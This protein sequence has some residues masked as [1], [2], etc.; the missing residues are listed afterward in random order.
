L[1]LRGL[2]HLEAFLRRVPDLAAY[3]TPGQSNFLAEFRNSTNG[4]GIPGHPSRA[5]LDELEVS[6]A[7][8]R[9]AWLRIARV[10]ARD[11][12]GDEHVYVMYATSHLPDRERYPLM[13]DLLNEWQDLPGTARRV[14][15][16]ASHGYTI[17]VL[18]TPE[19]QKFLAA[20][21]RSD[22]AEIRAAGA[23]IARELKD[24]HDRERD[25]AAAWQAEEARRKAEDAAARSGG[26]ADV[27]F[28]PLTFTVTDGSRSFDQSSVAGCTP[29]GP[30]VDAFS[31]RQGGVYLMKEPGQ[32]RTVWRPGEANVWPTGVVFD[33]RYVWAAVRRHGK[34]PRL[35]VIDPASEQVWEVTEADGLPTPTIED[36]KRAVMIPQTLRLAAIEPGRVCV[37]GY[38]GRTWLA[39]AQVDP[40]KGPAA[41]RSVKVFHEARA[42][43]TDESA[44]QWRDAGVIFQPGFMRTLTDPASARDAKPRR[45]IL[46]GRGGSSIEVR[47]HPLL[48]DAD[49]LR[50][51]V[52]EDEAFWEEGTAF[53]TVYD[54]VSADGAGVYWVWPGLR[55]HGEP[56]GAPVVHRLGFPDFRREALATNAYTGRQAAYRDKIY[57]HD[58]RCIL[59]ARQW[60]VADTP[61]GPF[62]MLH[63]DVPE[64]L[65]ADRPLVAART[66]PLISLPEEEKEAVISVYPSN[67]YGLV[68]R[69]SIGRTYRVTFARP[70]NPGPAKR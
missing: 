4:W 29:A 67:H 10:R 66:R 30:G 12:R 37:A 21:A 51:R 7:R 16:F 13:L 46:I 52:V 9:D 27:T 47:Y 48:V 1:Y 69:T 26:P 57:F 60:W 28:E 32:L 22:N 24:Y 5:A 58:H 65:D 63:G 31:T 23:A 39:I 34:S 61:A 36:P 42:V 38:F 64:R 17:D 43:A 20:L 49:T 33:G 14:R 44:T 45:T 62:R 25:A 55:Q 19:G 11:R 54:N 68:C 2:D 8:E 41:G 53:E 35:M 15:E 70:S 40:A 56:S 18:D 50:V 6:R 59:A 3:R